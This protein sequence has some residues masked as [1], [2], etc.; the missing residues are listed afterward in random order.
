MRHMK[1]I[2]AIMLAVAMILAMSVT[3]FAAEPSSYEIKITQNAEDTGTHT[4][5]AY[6]IF[7]G[8]LKDGKISNIA[9]ADGVTINESTAKNISD[10]LGITVSDAQDAEKVSKALA[11]LA[12]NAPA[13]YAFADAMDGVAVLEQTADAASGDVVIT[14][15]SGGYYLVKDTVNPTVTGNQ[16]AS[17]TRFIVKV[18]G[19]T[20]PTVVTAKSSVPSIVKNVKD[21]NDT[22]NETSGWI[23]SADYDLNDIVPYRL[24]IS[25]GEG[26]SNYKAYYLEIADTMSDG[27]A[28]QNDLVVVVDYDGDETT[29]ADQVTVTGAAFDSG[30]ASTIKSATGE[31]LGAKK[32]TCKIQDLFAVNG[33]TKANITSATKIFATYTAK[34]TGDAVQYGKPGNPN[35]VVL[36]YGSNPNWNG[37]G[38]PDKEET[39][40]DRNI[41]FT[42]K[43]VV[44]KFGDNTDTPVTGAEFKLYKEIKNNVEGTDVL[45]V[46][47]ITIETDGNVYTAKG[48]D[49]GTYILQETKAPD[50]Y[51]LI[52]GSVTFN[53]VTYDHAVSFKVQATHDSDSADPQLVSLTGT[54]D[55]G[56]EGFTMTPSAD[57]SELDAN[58]VDKS[59]STLPSTGG[60]GTTMF[61][62]IGMILVTGAGVVLVTRK[63]MAH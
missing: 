30:V 28:Y 8:D 45:S 9:W 23:D 33:I 3:A 41:V 39:P 36:I 32:Y 38:T 7:K 40:K 57:L 25:L 50:G 19:S 51:N 47:E 5:A 13:L 42:Y 37:T 14:G 60:V 10:A 49:D 12:D 1:K 20:N 21:K 48:L 52:S 11:T 6:K 34:L 63:R 17:Q 4:Y 15:L 56:M 59:G 18:T 29:V 54:R 62:V 16:K 46:Q 24:K 43:T 55:Q 27:L 44:N 61:Y 35:D 22:E 31:D 26:I 53:S 58:V 2:F